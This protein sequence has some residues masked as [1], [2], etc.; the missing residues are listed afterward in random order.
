MIAKTSKGGTAVSGRRG[1]PPGREARG[2]VREIDE[3]IGRLKKGISG[4]EQLL[5]ERERLLRGTL[6]VDG[7]AEREGRAGQARL[8]G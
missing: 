6:R 3:E 4:Y 2:V 8:S 7:R 1:T 5:S